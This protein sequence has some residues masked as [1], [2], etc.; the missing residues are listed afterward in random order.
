MTQPTNQLPN[1]PSPLLRDL[2]AIVLLWVL[3]IAFF[4][5]IALAGRVLAGGDIF[6]YFYPYWAEATR[7]IRAGRLPLWNPYL[8]MGTPLLANSQVGVFYPFN[9]PLWLFLSAHQSIHLTIVLHLCLVAFNG[10]L[11][12]R[13]SLR[14][15]RAGAWMVGATFALGGYLGAQVEHVNQL[16]G[17]VWLPLALTLC[18]RNFAPNHK[19]ANRKSANRKA[20]FAGLAIVVSLVFLAGHTQ[21]AFISLVGLAAYGLG[22]VLWRGLR[23]R[24][25]RPLV[26]RASRLAAVAGLGVALAAV[27]LLPTW[28]L[29]RLSVRAGGLPF[30]ERVSFSL[31][32]FYLARALLPGFAEPVPPE[33]IEHVAYVGIAGLALAAVAILHSPSSILHSPSSILHPPF[34]TLQSSLF[35]LT[36]GLFLSLGL[37]NPL[38]LLLARFVPGFAHFRVPARWLSLYAI[39]VASLVGWGWDA[40]YHRRVRIG[41]RALLFF[42]VALVVLAGWAVVGV[43]IGEGGHV[44]WPT[45]AGWTIGIV[46]ALGLLLASRRAPRPAAVGLLA[47][48][49]V[50]LF[51]A[52][53]AL[54]HS[55]ATAP[56]A[57]TS[58]RPAIAHLLSAKEEVGEPPAR[59]ISMSDITF[60][61]GDL[62]EIRIIYGPQLSADALYDYVVAAKHKEVLSPNLPLAFGL[63]AV[64][65]YDGGV[66]PLARYVTLQHLFLTEDEVSID[67]R[68]RENLTGIPDG[69]WLSLFNVRYVITDKL[70]DAWLDDVFYDLQFGAQLL[71]GETAA[72]AHV[73]RFEATALG[74]VS[75]LRG[76]AALPDGTPVGLVEVGFGEGITRRFELRAGQH[77]AEGLYGPDVAHAQAPVGGHFWP[78]ALSGV[79]GGQPE[80]SD[81]VTRL[82]WQEPAAPATVV[83]RAMLP[84]G[85]LVVRGVSLIDERTGGFQPLVLSDR[86]RFRLVH[87]GDV[88]IYENLNVLERAFIVHRAIVADDATTVLAS[89]QDPAFDPAAEVI[90]AG[91]ADPLRRSESIV[92]MTPGLATD[93]Q[94]RRPAAGSPDPAGANGPVGAKGGECV[95]VTHYAPEHV[96]IEVDAEAPGYLVLTDSWYPGWEATVDG[97]PVPIYQADL[98]FRAVAV[99]AGRH[100]VV[101][102]FR[103]V[104]LLI[105]AGVSLAGLVALVIV[106][107]LAV[108]KSTPT[109]C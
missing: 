45:V 69:R 44:G 89:M 40:L 58:L 62:P 55:R 94:I 93:C 67:G 61:P 72:V 33:H 108:S 70:H 106:A 60:D 49:V 13:G 77:T 75:H 99:D 56:Q 6:T 82:R 57:F 96:E 80:G 100:R 9:W 3:V 48:L 31:S 36:L 41:W 14:M 47:L 63:P 19:S 105:G 50:E 83:V 51:A 30:N 46:S 107:A 42:A 28:E 92:E 74:I 17:L 39:G 102:V 34:S 101:F 91:E 38:Y 4:W 23:Q 16:Q 88:K 12:G 66:L 68:L 29:S 73:P 85:E 78:P 35:I 95:S 10:Y 18:D 59:F 81:Y 1:Q 52:G 54:P 71:H 8:F 7:A 97:E 87:S 64:D 86:G 43:R 84:E 79:A 25:W 5:K 20:A 109:L 26:R 90:L 21:T 32:P 2:L 24:E 76:G 37:Y 11:W 53:S 103:P 27:Q 65:G 22:P 104:S 98:L 15:G